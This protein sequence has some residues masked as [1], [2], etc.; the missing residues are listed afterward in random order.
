MI[1]GLSGLIQQAAEDSSFKIGIWVEF[2]FILLF[3]FIQ[4]F[5]LPLLVLFGVKHFVISK[6]AK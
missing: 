1:S 6:G 3:Y 4:I 2:H 5:F